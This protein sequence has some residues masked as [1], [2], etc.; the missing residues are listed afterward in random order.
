[1]SL[2]GYASIANEE[3]ISV[4][5][6]KHEQVGEGIL[7]VVSGRNQHGDQRYGAHLEAKGAFQ[8]AKAY[9]KAQRNLFKIFLYGHQKVK[10]AFAKWHEANP[11]YK[12]KSSNGKPEQQPAEPPISALEQAQNSA[13][14]TLRDP[15]TMKV[16]NELGV[17]KTSDVHAAATDL[18]GDDNAWDVVKWQRYRTEIVNLRNKK[19]NLYT[20]LLSNAAKAA[21]PEATEPEAD[22]KF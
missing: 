20:R 3:G 8:W 16:L 14:N 10:D 12:G 1:M 11:N 5:T 2:A 21:E 18:W 9:S 4:D 15:A 19:G 22:V 7:V 13:R 6:C 17:E